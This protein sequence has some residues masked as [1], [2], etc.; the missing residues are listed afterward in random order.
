MSMI[1]TG[2]AL[3]LGL[4]C[5]SPPATPAEEDAPDPLLDMAF[6]DLLQITV[7][8]VSGTEETIA[9]APASIV[10]LTADELRQR[11]YHSLHEIFADLPGF[12]SYVTNGSR[13]ITAYQRGYRTPL[14]SRTLFLLNGR[15]Q[16]HLWDHVAYVQRQWPLS[17]IERVEILY[18]P[19]SVI[20]GPNAFLGVV[21]IITR[22]PSAL[23]DGTHHLEAQLGLGSWNTRNLDINASGRRGK[24]SYQL[25]GRLFRSDEADLEDM[26]KDYG[27]LNNELLG[28][29]AIWGPLLTFDGPSMGTYGDPSDNWGLVGE[30]N[31]DN[32]QLAYNHWRLKEGYGLEFTADSAQPDLDWFK[33]GEEYALSHQGQVDDRLSVASLFSYRT[34]RLH[35]DWAEANPA[36]DNP[37][38]S[39]ISYSY[40]NSRNWAQLFQQDYKYRYNDQWQFNGGIKH[41]FKHLTKAW[42]VCGYW[43]G[44]LCSSAADR[45]GPLGFG[46]GI[47]DS[48]S[49]TYQIQPRP[50]KSV[51]S[52]NINRTRENGVYLQ[53]IYDKDSWR[54]SGGL[55]YDH[56]SDYGSTINPRVSLLHRF[57]SEH[58]LKLLY[59]EAFQEPPNIL[60][61]GGWNGRRANP[62]L[63]PETLKHLEAIY[64][65]Q[66]PHWLHELSLYISR[67]KDV[68]KEEALNAGEREVLGIEYRGNFH[69]HNLLPGREDI[70]GQLY[71]TYTDNTSSIRYLYDH[72]DPD[73]GERRNDWF[74]GDT[75]IGDIAPHKLNLLLNWPVARHWNLNLRYQYHGST[76]LYSRNRLRSQGEKLDA[77]QLVNMALQY[78]FEPFTATLKIDNLFNEKYFIPGTQAADAGNDFDAPRSAGFRPSLTPTPERSYMLMLNLNF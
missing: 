35:G 63:K 34:S 30:V 36:G 25:A 74:E 21:N 69:W 20:Y 52:R 46:A 56:H 27:W 4:L 49:P 54:F 55:R 53:G 65:Y 61:F 44:A 15:T 18:G 16:N 76:Q 47:F 11:G 19:A 32:W 24:F 45:P 2:F 60:L 50:L 57:N 42:D 22:D 26:G 70:S 12:D 78:E 33:E 31:Y 9:D 5:I 37:A 72:L 14:M 13:Y 7:T 68:I 41:E 64:L 6:E 43:L 38:F 28:S 73:S 71:Y 67:Y 3:A 59:S 66:Q 51:P 1:R 62:D 23:Q 29:S 48:R 10:V 39:Y 75:D 77:Y 58:S 8:S 40:W 17:N